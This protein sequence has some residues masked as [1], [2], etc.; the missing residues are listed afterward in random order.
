MAETPAQKIAVRFLRLRSERCRISADLHRLVMLLPSQIKEKVKLAMGQEKDRLFLLDRLLGPSE[1]HPEAVDKEPNLETVDEV[2]DDTVLSDKDS[3]DSDTDDEVQL[4]N[5]DSVAD[6]LITGSPFEEFKRNL[7][8]FLHPEH[9]TVT[10]QA[11]EVAVDRPNL[12]PPLD[13]A[14]DQEHSGAQEGGMP[15]PDLKSIVDT[16]T[17]Q[18]TPVDYSISTYQVPLQMLS[19]WLWRTMCQ[20]L[21]E[22]YHRQKTSIRVTLS[23][24]EQGPTLPWVYKSNRLISL[25]L[26][27]RR[28]SLR[29][30]LSRIQRPR[31]KEG[32]RRIEWTCDC[33]VDLYAD[34][35]VPSGGSEHI[36][37][38]AL[39]LQSSAGSGPS[40]AG[41]TTVGYIQQRSSGTSETLSN[42]DTTDCPSDSQSSSSSSSPASSVLG[43]VSVQPQPTGAVRPKYLALCVNTGGIYKTLAEVDTTGTAS[44]AAGFEKMKQAYVATRGRRSRFGFLIKPVGIEFVQFTLWNLRHGYVSICNRPESIPPHTTAEYEYLPK[45]LDPL[46]PMPP[47]IFIHYLEHGEGGLN[48]A[49]HD[50]LPRLPM[51]VGKRVI[52][53]EEACYGWGLHVI[54]GPNR[55]VVFWLMMATTVASVLACALWAQIKEDMQGATGLGG[56]IVALPPSVL[57]AFLFRL[58]SV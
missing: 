52:D 31:L 34:L 22:I 1:E 14:S 28:M 45:P 47:E 25:G 57:A 15:E 41:A 38:L 10:G 35:R 42:S 40:T 6:F 9:P 5:L 36:D 37:A 13:D 4:T 12:Q 24:L 30:W 16:G 33:G 11:P 50:W 58:G 7:Q 54:E 53:G 20:R 23:R 27:V 43:S 2:G 49:R 46:P 56:L 44:D 51:R 18:E 17:R 19:V 29:S 3:E 39:S 8:K 32:H 48:P 21:T 55:E 26:L